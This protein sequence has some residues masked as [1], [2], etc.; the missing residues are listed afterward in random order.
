M[1][2]VRQPPPKA[3]PASAAGVSELFHV[4]QGAFSR[5]AEAHK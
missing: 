3:P 1:E 5:N 4:E 2:H